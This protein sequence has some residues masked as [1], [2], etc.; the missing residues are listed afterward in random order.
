MALWA[1]LEERDNS[2]TRV[3]VK[4]ADIARHS[5]PRGDVDLRIEHLE[6][7]AEL[8]VFNEQEGAVAASTPHCEEVPEPGRA[9]RRA[10][11]IGGDHGH[12]SGILGV[13][14]LDVTPDVRRRVL[15]V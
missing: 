3:R 14:A 7:R 11:R 1:N 5:E 10:R 12:L 4:E 2:N 6:D 13:A 8:L 9:V 15:V